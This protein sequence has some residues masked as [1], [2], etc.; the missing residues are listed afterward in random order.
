MNKF[1]SYLLLVL[2]SVGT[3]SVA[4][5]D[6][7]DGYEHFTAADTDRWPGILSVYRN[8][9]RIYLE[10]ADSLLGRNLIVTAQVD[11]GKGMA[12]HT[13][14]TPGVFRFVR[15]NG[16]QLYRQHSRHYEQTDET[17]TSLAAAAEASNF[18]P[19]DGVFAITCTN[20]ETRASIIDITEALSGRN[21]WF[22][23]SAA[24][25]RFSGSD[26]GLTEAVAAEDGVLFIF[27]R[28]ATGFFRT[29]APGMKGS[30]GQ[31]E[32]QL[33]CMLRLLPVD[34]MQ[35]RRAKGEAEFET[36][37]YTLYS[38][39]RYEAARDSLLIRWRL[40]I[41]PSKRT[42]KER[43]AYPVEP[44][45]FHIDPSCPE[46]WVPAI[47]SAIAAWNRSFE[48]LGFRDALQVVRLEI[49]GTARYRA[50]IAWDDEDSTPS[51]DRTVDP[52][53]GEILACRIRIG[54]KAFEGMRERYL[55]Q[56]GLRDR[57]IMDDF[58]N[59]QVMEEL[60]RN[61]VAR[62]I[63]RSLG[64]KLPD[65]DGFIP[66]ES[67]IA[68][69]IR[70]YGLKEHTMVSLPQTP[71]FQKRLARL[72]EAMKTLGA[73]YARA[74]SYASDRLAAPDAERWLDRLHQAKAQLYEEYLDRAV[75]LAFGTVNSREIEKVTDFLTLYLFADSHNPFDSGD[76]VSRTAFGRHVLERV[77]DPRQG[78][79]LAM[80][81]DQAA[82]RDSNDG[83]LLGALYAALRK[84]LFDDFGDTTPSGFAMNMQS[85]WVDLL[86][87]QATDR[88]VESCDDEFCATLYF[89]L[90]TLY[91]QLHTAAK[92]HPDSLTRRL[93]AHL[94]RKISTKITI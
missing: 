7:T 72:D 54:R 57:R 45:I 63:G 40:E 19:V 51:C 20:P 6:H 58:E 11:Q 85:C 74:K 28:P 93:Y 79:L 56:N 46:P 18:S 32:V 48:Q 66:D 2:L 38:S 37:G 13:L 44:I 14:P 5:S 8:N 47:T 75:N 70:G 62:E 73:T 29:D 59:R 35:V 60:V 71:P 4:A 39:S 52:L 24:N 30:S 84:S 25:L 12:G 86:V 68:A 36:V 67:H 81:S 23:V 76:E 61:R 65:G 43:T 22:D 69:I 3:G 10:I 82:I 33:S 87:K 26:P 53:T 1:A 94:C 34:R 16:R 92:Q 42:A 77:S 49:P 80:R 90:R 27:K 41:P 89:E 55:L 50:L 31:T 83:N 15:G 78:T 21:G 9:G 17:G 88:H 91:T 64:L